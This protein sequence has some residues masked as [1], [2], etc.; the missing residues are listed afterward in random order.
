MPTPTWPS[1]GSEW[2]P[3]PAP[4]KL[5]EKPRGV[6]CLPGSDRG[7]PNRATDRP[8]SEALSPHRTASRRRSRAPP[9]RSPTRCQGSET[10]RPDC[11]LPTT[12]H[13]RRRSA[14]RTSPRAFAPAR[15]PRRPRP[16]AGRRR[17]AASP[18]AGSAPGDRRA[19]SSES[20]WLPGSRP[21]QGFAR[22]R[23]PLRSRR[24]PRP[25]RPKLPA[26]TLSRR[27][28]TRSSSDRSS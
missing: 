2:V 27:H 4:G 1:L 11:D 8:P 26:N 28:K 17:A 25:R 21:G 5:P 23:A 13:P 14:R 7:P 10:S 22:A 6:G 20:T 9:R 3:A 19:P 16:D 18:T 15:R 12:E 24:P